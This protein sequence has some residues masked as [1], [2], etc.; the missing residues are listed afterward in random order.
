[1]GSTRVL[2]EDARNSDL[3][4]LGTE[5]ACWASL[6]RGKT[7]TKLNNNLPTVAIHEIAVHPTAGEIVAATHGRSLWVLDVSALRQM[8]ADVMTKDMFLYEPN[9]VVRWRNEPSRGA[10]YGAG[11]RMYSGQNPPRGAQVYYSLSRKANNVTL[12]VVDISGKSV[13]EL[14]ASSE[15]GLHVVPWDL[16]RPAM[17][18]MARTENGVYRVVLTVDGEEQ[19][20]PLR[21]EG[22]PTLP[23]NV[24]TEEELE[25]PLKKRDRRPED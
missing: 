15:K 16:M 6:N 24:V 7:W 23:A 2:R 21:L 10:A 3:L 22:D 11:S 19:S 17:T 18:G 4:Y 14:K 25:H 5:F 13:R 20:Q 8:K 12:K 1:L 9:K